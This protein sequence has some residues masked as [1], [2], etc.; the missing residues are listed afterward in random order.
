M[1]KLNLPEYDIRVKSNKNKALIFDPFRKKYLVLTPEEWVRQHFLNFLV[2]IKGYPASRIGVEVGLRL[3]GTQKR[4]DIVVYDSYGRPLIIVECKASSVPITQATF[5]QIARYNMV[6]NVPFLVVS[7]GMQHYY[8]I[9][10]HKLKSYHFLED[11]PAFN[12]ES[13]K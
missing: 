9:M 1:E 8:C 6:L 2:S 5:D 11:L 12:S 4:A 7:N 10:D 13:K 3:N